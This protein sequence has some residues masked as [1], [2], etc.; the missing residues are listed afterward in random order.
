MFFRHATHIWSNES[1]LKPGSTTSPIF[2]IVHPPFDD[3]AQEFLVPNLL[4]CSSED[5]TIS[6]QLELS[7]DAGI[8][9]P[10][11]VIADLSEFS[12]GPKPYSG[13]G[14]HRSIALCRPTADLPIISFDPMTIAFRYLRF[15]IEVGGPPNNFGEA[16]FMLASNG[17]VRVNETIRKV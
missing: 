3:F 14:P 16:T 4:Q 6:A 11:S 1:A 7:V 12:Q 10:G 17:P 15:H 9:F 2:E 13:Q 8:W 5:G